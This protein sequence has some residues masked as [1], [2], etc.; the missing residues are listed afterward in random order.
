[1][2]A[3]ALIGNTSSLEI[4]WEAPEKGIPIGYKVYIDGDLVAETDTE[5]LTY[6]HNG[7]IITNDKAHIAEV[8]AIYDEIMTSVRVAKVIQKTW[9]DNIEENTDINCNIYPN[10]VNDRLYIETL[11]L[12]Q[13][14]IYDVFGRRQVT[15]TPS[16]Q[17]NVA[18][19]VEDLKSGIYFV[20]I[21]TEKG[22]IV[23]RIIKD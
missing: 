4:K 18:I 14:E 11:T 3:E 6:V 15:E 12:T 23:K 17:G 16:H 21:N 1:M 22:N 7:N 5:T 9:V 2:K 13:I 10:P 19:D 20:K 8:V